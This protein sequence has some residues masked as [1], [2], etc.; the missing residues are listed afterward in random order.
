[1]DEVKRFSLEYFELCYRKI[2]RLQRE[3]AWLC[4]TNVSKFTA[5]I[6][7]A[8][9]PLLLQLSSRLPGVWCCSAYSSPFWQCWSPVWA[10][11]APTSW[12]GT[13]R[14]RPQQ[15]CSVVSCSYLQ[16]GSSWDTVTYIFKDKA[17]CVPIQNLL[18]LLDKGHYY[19]VN[20]NQECDYEIIINIS[21][22]IM[23]WISGIKQF[24]GILKKP[25]S[26][27]KPQN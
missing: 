23:Q 5:Y 15:L 9:L 16:V 4:Q 24:T 17:I 6:W 12:M 25:E 14:A 26:H 10:W 1:M 8:F 13:L 21:D 2:N 11:S 3:G 20:K 19:K 27:L 22:K 7:P 18:S